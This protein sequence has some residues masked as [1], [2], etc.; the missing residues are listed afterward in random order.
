MAAFPCSLLKSHFH[1]QSW[2]R[3]IIAEIKCLEIL[4]TCKYNLLDQIFFSL[5]GYVMMSVA[6]SERKKKRNRGLKR[7]LYYGSLIQVK[8]KIRNK[9]Q[10]LCIYVFCLLSLVC[11][12]FMRIEDVKNI[13]I[14]EVITDAQVSFKD[15]LLNALLLYSLL[16]KC[17]A[18]CSL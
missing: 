12:L 6:E 8:P 4:L 17:E 3:L 9:N 14:E 11:L 2:F 10:L 13:Y 18:I 16:I 1:F 7:H 15:Q 5:L